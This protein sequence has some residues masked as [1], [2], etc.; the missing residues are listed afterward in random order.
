[1]LGNIYYLNDDSNNI[2]IDINKA[3][4]FYKKAVSKGCVKSMNNL[5]PAL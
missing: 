4:I 1:M 2:E 5:S 3:I